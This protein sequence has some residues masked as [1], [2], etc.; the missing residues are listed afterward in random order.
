MV[1]VFNLMTHGLVIA[2]CAGMIGF[3]F[4]LI[5]VEGRTVEGW[6]YYNS[7]VVNDI[8]GVERAMRGIGFAI[9]LMIYIGARAVGLSIPQMLTSAL[10]N[11]NPLTVGFIGTL[12][13]AAVGVLMAWYLVR[14][15][16]KDD[17]IAK[18]TLIIL[19]G[20][21][22]LM[23]GDIYVASFGE[24]VEREAIN[25][26]LLP[27]LSFILGMGLYAVFNYVPKRER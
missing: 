5:F 21:I 25:R 4:F 10:S 14:Q 2:T 6:G 1:A 11:I 26:Y 9:G 3:G 22:L 17:L 27:N 20:F 7:R 8:P 13:P 16:D 12:A 24:Y 18:R 19:T 23:F 15:I